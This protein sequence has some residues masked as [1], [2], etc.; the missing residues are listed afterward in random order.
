[1]DR[2]DV[3]SFFIGGF[4]FFLPRVLCA[5]YPVVVFSLVVWSRA[6]RRPFARSATSI[7]RIFA[8]VRG[9]R[10]NRVLDVG[11]DAVSFLSRRGAYPQVQ[12]NGV[13]FS[14][15]IGGVHIAVAIDRTLRISQRRDR[16]CLPD[17][18]RTDAR[19]EAQSFVRWW[20]ASQRATDL[21]S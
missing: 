21:H 6:G 13:F 10:I 1:M 11:R 20:S 5:K 18:R 14:S 19:H 17:F 3:R 12:R 15:G 4:V 9:D 2:T 16:A 8:P 7:I